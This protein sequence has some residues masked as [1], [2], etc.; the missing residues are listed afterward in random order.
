MRYTTLSAWLQW[1]ESC[2]PTAIDLGL[3]RVSAVAA[4][5]GTDVS[6]STVVSV[7]GTNGKGSCVAALERLCLAAGL[8]VGCYTSPHFLHYNERIRLQ[9]REVDDAAIMAAF[10]RVDKALQGESLTYFEFGTLAALDIFQA[11]AVDVMVLE[12]GL[13][14]RLDAVNLVDADIAIVTA[15]GLDHLD[16]LGP[17]RESIGREK[18][19]IFRRGK[20]AICADSEVP[21]SVVD[22]AN[23]IGAQLLRRHRDFDLQLDGD[24]YLWWSGAEPDTAVAVDGLAQL[25]LPPAS[26]AAAFQ[27][28]ELLNIGRNAWS[29][30][31][32]VRL[33]GRGQRLQLQGVELLLDVAHNPQAAAYLAQRLRASPKVGR[34]WALFAVMADKDIAGMIAALGDCFDHWCVATIA[35]VSRAASAEQLVAAV[36]RV[37]AETATPYASMEEAIAAILPQLGASDQLV[38]FGS[39]FTVAAVIDYAQTQAAANNLGG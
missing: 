22:H 15:I 38:V 34:R 4:R 29:E 39:F 19:G 24:R 36:T 26:V 7:A 27:A 3:E 21:A 11:A 10:D 31:A 8:K 5:L 14:G 32:A 1:L 18:A 25:A 2:H 35:G 30:V 12:V 9:G 16:W 13:G 17:D 20:P 33:P 28:A 37:E 23:Q 6:A